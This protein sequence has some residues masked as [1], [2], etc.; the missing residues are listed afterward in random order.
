MSVTTLPLPARHPGHP[1]EYEEH[2]QDQLP[3]RLRAMLG[4]TP[5]RDDT[6]ALWR[7]IDYLPD[8]CR[9][10]VPEPVLEALVGWRRGCLADWRRLSRDPA[11]GIC[12]RDLADACAR[13]TAEAEAE[14]AATLQRR[15]ATDPRTAQWLLERRNPA[16][17]GAGTADVAEAISRVVAAVSRALPDA[18]PETLRQAL[19]AAAEGK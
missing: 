18:D 17:W 11:W 3:E 9:L 7:V 19:Q 16:R 14:L 15:G 12:A 4:G 13:G 8:L 10:G 2:W 6:D 5:R 1:V